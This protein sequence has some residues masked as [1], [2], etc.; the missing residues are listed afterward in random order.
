[1][2][3]T[4]LILAIV[5]GGLDSIGEAVTRLA[6]YGVLG[7]LAGLFFG[8]ISWSA[9]TYRVSGGAV[10]FKTGIFRVKEQS[11]PLDRLQSVDESEGPLQRL[12][13]VRQLRLQAA[14]SG[15]DAE[16]VLNALAPAEVTE[17]RAALAEGAAPA[18]RDETA[19]AGSVPSPDA[20]APPRRLTNGRLF[21]AGLTSAQFG[22]LVPVAAVLVQ[23]LDDVAEPLFGWLTDEGESLS[24]VPFL[25][26]LGG[27]LAAAWLFAFAGTLIG[28]GGFVV[29]RRDDRLVIERG[30]VVRRQ[31]SV[32]VARVQ[33]VRLVDG[34]LRQPLGMTQLRL[35]TAGYFDERADARTLFP[36]LRRD[37]VPAFLDALL[38]ELA[39]PF[40]ALE[41]P[42]RRALRRYVALPAVAGAL[43]GVALAAAASPG[44]IWVAA[45]G[46]LV[47]AAWGVM[48]FRAAGIAL[49][50]ERLVVRSR[51]V[52]RS[53][54]VARRTSVDIRGTSQTPLQRKARLAS[55]RFAIASKHSFGIAHVEQREATDVLRALA[56]LAR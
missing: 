17:L 7:L 35:E 38:P 29:S 32:P 36:L 49:G 48:R 43:P 21:L 26:A 24:V 19:P 10:R 8:Y 5:S 28:F 39:A 55:L 18:L 52:A 56:P 20:S 4:V 14:G 22:F 47:G 40:D 27:V 23:G 30:W 34:I 11:I 1:M 33:A 37:E 15:K 51:R 41:P 31:A 54:V 3:F 42:P 2:A 50:S 12:F 44:L 45:A 53:T 25:L 13:G 46:A 9:T 6:I 16:I